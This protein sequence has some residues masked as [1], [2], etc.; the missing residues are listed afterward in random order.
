MDQP[1]KNKLALTRLTGSEGRTRHTF[2]AIGISGLE[3]GTAGIDVWVQFAELFKGNVFTFLQCI[4]A[5]TRRARGF[6]YSPPS[7]TWR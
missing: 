7:C 2:N 3:V 1:L 6:V 4:L 5:C